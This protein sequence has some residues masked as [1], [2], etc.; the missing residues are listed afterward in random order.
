MV[1]MVLFSIGIMSMAGLIPLG[2]RAI[3]RAGHQTRAS[4]VAAAAGERLL[5][6]PYDD[7]DLTAGTH[8]DPN[9]P[10]EGRYFV[11]WVVEEDQPITLCKR[12]T[13][14][15]RWGTSSSTPQARVVVVRPESSG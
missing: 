4:E 14:L 3:N 1:A 11:S 2:S 10:V 9:N 5:S 15:V 6:T 8:N 13:V 12:I 7:A